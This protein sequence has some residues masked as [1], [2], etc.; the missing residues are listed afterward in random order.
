MCLLI[1]LF[2]DTDTA[3]SDYLFSSVIA[4]KLRIRT[5]QSCMRNYLQAMVAEIPAD[6]ANHANTVGTDQNK[7]VLTGNAF[8]QALT[9]T[10]SGF[11]PTEMQE[12]SVEYQILKKKQSLFLFGLKPLETVT[13]C[14][15]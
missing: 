11:K 9:S 13:I 1:T 4:V 14:N 8:F 2:K 15:F 3:S 5:I 7:P 6:E 10:N 12:T